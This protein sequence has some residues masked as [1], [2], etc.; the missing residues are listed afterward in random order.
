MRDYEFLLVVE[1]ICTTLFLSR[2][3]I[4]YCLELLTLFRDS[5]TH[6]YKIDVMAVAC[7]YLACK[8]SE[9]R[10]RIR[11]IINVVHVVSS[12]YRHA[13]MK[14]GEENPELYEK[15]EDQVKYVRLTKYIDGPTV[16]DINKLLPAFS[17]NKYLKIREE[18]LEAEQ[19][20]LRIIDFDTRNEQK[21]GF[22]MLLGYLE[23]LEWGQP[24]C[25]IAFTVFNDLI[26]LQITGK[27]HKNY[28]EYFRKARELVWAAIRASY[29]LG[30]Q[31]ADVSYKKPCDERMLDKFYL[32]RK[33]IEGR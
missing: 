29:L 26:Y 1:E 4:A 2:P 7:I 23:Y 13:N 25:Q 27:N 28:S 17:Y 14:A 22:V 3:T 30:T 9:E 18:V 15:S 6:S 8:N 33:K 19:H 5:D 11:D 12:L 20:L 32:D 16:Q 24:A 10:R 31:I 21:I